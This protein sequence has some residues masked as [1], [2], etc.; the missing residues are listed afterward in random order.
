MFFWAGYLDFYLSSQDFRNKCFK[1]WKEAITLLRHMNRYNIIST[2]FFWL[3]YHIAHSDSKEGNL[4]IGGVP[5][6]F[7]HLLSITALHSF[8]SAFTISA[9]KYWPSLLSLFLYYVACV[10]SLIFQDFTLS[11]QLYV[12]NVS[13]CD[14]LY[15]YLAWS[16][17]KYLDL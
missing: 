16:F 12:Y 6:K 4:S 9:E 15:I 2:I 5:K 11:F 7:N 14:F 17:L 13:N 10:F 1:G 3:C 8:L